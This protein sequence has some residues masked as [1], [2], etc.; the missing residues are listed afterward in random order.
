MRV[1]IHA[2][3]LLASAL[4]VAQ[5]MRI[6]G[7]YQVDVKYDYEIFEMDEYISLEEK[8]EKS[9]ANGKIIISTCN[10]TNESI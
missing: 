1:I 3:F 7:D 6:Y 10:F 9:P 8:E 4:Y 5:I 2:Q